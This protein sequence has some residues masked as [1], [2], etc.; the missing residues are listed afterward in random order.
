MSQW[1]CTRILIRPKATS[2]RRTGVERRKHHVVHT[3]VD[4]PIRGRRTA[5]P[6]G[7]DTRSRA[8]LRPRDAPR[9]AVPGEAAD[10]I[11]PGLLLGGGEAVLA[12]SRYLHDGG[13]LLGRAHPEPDL[14]RGVLW[15][16]RPRGDC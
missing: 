16:D 9:R 15:T 14:P 1:T 7:T 2:P 11:R 12:D 4:D 3:P 10:P 5:R 6:V 13:R 8:P